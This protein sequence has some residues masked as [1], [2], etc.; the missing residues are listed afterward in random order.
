MEGHIGVDTDSVMAH[1]VT[2]TIVPANEI[3]QGQDLLHRENAVMFADTR[4]EGM[5]T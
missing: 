2:G 4:Q 1:S 5:T 3:T